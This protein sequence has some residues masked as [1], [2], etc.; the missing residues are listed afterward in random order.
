MK[1]LL[2]IVLLFFSVNCFA[3]RAW[4]DEEKEW[5]AVTGALLVADWS[6]S[7]NLT[8]RY[9]EGYYETNPVL[10]RYPTTQQMN[11]HF[12]VGIPLI[13]I[14]ADYL[15]E[16]RKQILMITSLIEFTAVGNNLNVGL[17][18]DF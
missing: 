18:F 17:H 6:T 8:R 12:L 9:N 2:V 4:T 1:K 14:A 11:L 16:Y 10:G 7:I 3:E 15:P 5:G 13:F